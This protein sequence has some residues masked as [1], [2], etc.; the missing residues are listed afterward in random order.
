MSSLMPTQLAARGFAT[1][2]LTYLTLSLTDFR[3][4]E[5]PLIVYYWHSS[6]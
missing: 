6:R 4:K 1:F 3:A 2:I 5:R